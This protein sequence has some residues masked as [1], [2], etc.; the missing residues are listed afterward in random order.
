MLGWATWKRDNR[1][2]SQPVAKVGEILMVSGPLPFAAATRSVALS[3]WSS[4]ARIGG[5]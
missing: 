2:T 4:A 1:G 5:K 3:I